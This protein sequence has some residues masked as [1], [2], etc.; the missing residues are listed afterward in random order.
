MHLRCSLHPSWGQQP[1]VDCDRVRG[2]VMQPVPL[3]GTTT[4]SSLRSYADSD[5]CSPCP[6]RGQQH[7]PRTS[8][9]LWSSMQPAPLTG[10]ATVPLS[11][12]TIL[13][14]LRCSPHPSRGQQPVF[15][16]PNNCQN[17]RCSPYPSR[18]QQLDDADRR[19]V[20]AVP[21][22]PAPLTGTATFPALACPLL[23]WL[24]M[25]PA[26]LTGTTTRRTPW[27]HRYYAADAARAPHGDSDKMNCAPALITP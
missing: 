14:H 2:L 22:Q 11:D 10:T 15:D 8:H 9:I 24:P 25:Q 16:A 23:M 6:S 18:G 3:T 17:K 26:P 4:F 12:D 5:R 20:E 19:V 1:H 13:H 7:R 27:S 21:M